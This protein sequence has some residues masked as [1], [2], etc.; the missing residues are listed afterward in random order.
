MPGCQFREVPSE[1]SSTLTLFSTQNVIDWPRPPES[2]LIQ[3]WFCPD[4]TD[5]RALAL[6]SQLSSS[7]QTR[8]ENF[9]LSSDRLRY[10]GSRLF[11]RC[12]LARNLQQ[13]PPEI[14]LTE[15]NG[16][17]SLEAPAESALKFSISTSQDLVLIALARDSEDNL[18]RNVGV[19]LERLV[20]SLENERLAEQSFTQPEQQFVQ[21]AGDPTSAF[22]QIWTGKEAYRK[23]L[24]E[25]APSHL[26]F[27]A[28]PKNGAPVWTIDDWSASTSTRWHIQRV[29]LPLPNFCASLVHQ[30]GLPD[31]ELIEIGAKQIFNQRW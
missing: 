28:A 12:V 7:E 19:G 4:I 29:E 22:F 27:S 11:L 23:A 6:K 9:R 15:R 18:A 30:E 24:G 5:P 14:Q 20:P 8:V 13:A 26:D 31:F 1:W 21:Q 25:D 17:P 16:I 3:L 10:I 2:D